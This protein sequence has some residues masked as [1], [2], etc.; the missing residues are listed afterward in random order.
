MI[1][2]IFISRLLFGG[3]SNCSFNKWLYKAKACDRI[4]DAITPIE[5]FYRIVRHSPNGG[6]SGR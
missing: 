5:A 4:E 6:L 2:Q 1:L 3:E